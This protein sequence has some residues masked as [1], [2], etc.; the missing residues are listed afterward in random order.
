M[1][2]VARRYLWNVIKHARDNGVTVLLTTHSMEECEA[3]CTKLG[4]M[5]SGQFQCFGN[6]Q[7]L[8]NKFGKG[9][10]LILKCKTIP[11][12]NDASIDLLVKK[13]ENFIQENIPN[14]VLKDRQQQT[15][16]YQILIENNS[17]Y[18][19]ANIFELIEANKEILSLETYSLSQTTLEQV[20]LSFAKNQSEII[21]Q[22]NLAAANLTK[23][24]R[25]DFYFAN[26]AYNSDRN[27]VHI[28]F[29]D[30]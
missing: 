24:E 27:E 19:I 20:F 21:P 6:V 26:S 7:Q 28:N 11:S 12:M 30:L 5:V 14:T 8:K 9:Y 29:K 18:S 17:N 23:R 2:P 25:S 13:V 4:I 10:S 15:L 1:D 16:F 3:L 22:N